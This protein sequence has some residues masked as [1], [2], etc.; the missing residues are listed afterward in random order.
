MV[1]HLARAVE[2]LHGVGLI[3]GRAN[4]LLER[5]AVQRAVKQWVYSPLMLNGKPERFMLTVT[6]SFS[7]RRSN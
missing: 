3:G 7:L 5:Q 6:V 4:D 2:D 1:Q